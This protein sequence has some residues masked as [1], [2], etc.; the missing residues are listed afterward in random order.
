MLKKLFWMVNAAALLSG[1]SVSASA[2][3]LER[4]VIVETYAENFENFNLDKPY[5]WETLGDTSCLVVDK[6][7]GC[8][9]IRSPQGQEYGW[10]SLPLGKG[11]GITHDL[12]HSIYHRRNPERFPKNYRLQLR[13]KT[14]LNSSRDFFLVRLIWYADS[15]IIEEK[16]YPVKKAY[17][18]WTALEFKGTVPAGATQYQLSLTGP[19]AP[20]RQ[21]GLSFLVD[22]LSMKIYLQD[23]PVAFPP[24]DSLCAFKVNFPLNMREF[25]I[26][27]HTPWHPADWP[28]MYE[29]DPGIRTPFAGL[30]DRTAWYIKRDYWQRDISSRQYP[31]IGPYDAFDKE[32]IRWQV[33]TMRNTGLDGAFINLWPSREQNGMGYGRTE[34]IFDRIIDAAEENNFKVALYDENWEKDIIANA[35]RLVMFLKKYGRRDSY[36]RIN[37]QPAIW[38]QNWMDNYPY[39]PQELK[40]LITYVEGKLGTDLYWV[41]SLIRFNFPIRENYKEFLEIK[42]IDC[43]DF[44][45]AVEEI[46]KN[47]DTGE[48]SWYAMNEGLKDFMAYLKSSAVRHDWSA[49]VSPGFD[50]VTDYTRVPQVLYNGYVM[51]YQARNHGLMFLKELYLISQQETP[52]AFITIKSWND[53][54]EGH[55]IEPGY[56]YEG[57]KDSPFGLSR[58]PYFYTKLV[59]GALSK[60]FPP[61]ELPP[62]GHVD[63][64]VRP[65]LYEDQAGRDVYGPLFTNLEIRGDNFRCEIK[66]YNSSECRLF[67]DARPAAGFVVGNLGETEQWGLEISNLA[68][69]KENGKIVEAAGQK[70]LKVFDT[71]K[72]EL[73]LANEV[74]DQ[75]NVDSRLFM[76]LSYFDRKTGNERYS[77]IQFDYMSKDGMEISDHRI[78]VY[79]NA[80]WQWGVQCLYD[81][82]LKRDG[83]ISV[84]SR[85]SELLVHS[86]YV[87]VPGVSKNSVELKPAGAGKY[88]LSLGELSRPLAPEGLAVLYPRDGNGNYGNLLLLDTEKK[89]IIPDIKSVVTGK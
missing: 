17:S 57:D 3:I 53:Y 82:D 84:S 70:C 45:Y 28:Q 77:T 39:T 34:V 50:S 63:P 75:L 24:D 18:R 36:Y 52:P 21:A 66:D 73:R 85:G 87:V 55:A 20:Q 49:S 74:A 40:Q 15:E 51:P 1:S 19:P 65:L 81:A 30:W 26:W 83:R 68:G 42:E 59:A 31:L 10:A 88:I 78:R 38:M 80:I 32:I 16:N 29:I 14:S 60:T 58:D 43:V 56:Y 7:E 48:I 6:V 72:I 89:R 64:L 76:V 12:N 11:G 62:A 37:G 79:N 67:Q 5:R 22:D 33:R 13:V 4:P 44:R 35:A 27:W 86:L 2:K 71:E 69:L 54:H 41:I 23:I 25:H 46:A 8:I 9:G 47:Q 61:A